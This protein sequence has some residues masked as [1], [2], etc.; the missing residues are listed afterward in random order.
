MRTSLKVNLG[1]ARDSFQ[2][3]I[4]RRSTGDTPG[5]LG[6]ENI[7]PSRYSII[8]KADQFSF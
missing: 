3:Y 5:M 6:L 1:V 8:C 2:T 7:R 4:L